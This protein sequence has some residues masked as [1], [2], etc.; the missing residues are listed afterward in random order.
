[1]FVAGVQNHVTL[2][3]TG[4]LTPLY[5][6]LVVVLFCLSVV[7]TILQFL[8]TWYLLGQPVSSYKEQMNKYNQLPPPCR[9][10]HELSRRLKR[11]RDE[12]RSIA[13]EIRRI[14]EADKQLTRRLHL[15]NVEYRIVS[16]E[17]DAIVNEARICNTDEV[18]EK[19][20]RMT[21][22]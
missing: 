1:M 17:I 14:V 2:T 16:D 7:L 21:L 6:R 15:L 5:T 3:I 8:F 22:K 20:F 18:K 13:V 19:T 11:L 10:L 4:I 9:N 12:Q